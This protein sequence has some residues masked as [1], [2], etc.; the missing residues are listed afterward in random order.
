MYY[1]CVGD[2]DY[3]LPSSI[4]SITRFMKH[5]KP[6]QLC[7]D[8]QVANV[9]KLCLVGVRKME[10]SRFGRLLDGAPSVSLPPSV[11]LARAGVFRL[12]I[13]KRLFCAVRHARFQERRGRDASGE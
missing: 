11:D 6:R 8:P 13:V 12:A 9:D 10:S 1:Y 3:D 2:R 7:A 4:D 5:K